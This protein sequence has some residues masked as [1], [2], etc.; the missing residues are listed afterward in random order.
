MFTFMFTLKIRIN[1]TQLDQYVT[2]DQLIF[3][4]MTAAGVVNK[5][6]TIALTHGK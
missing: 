4:P 5:T 2:I 6:S 3:N 1:K